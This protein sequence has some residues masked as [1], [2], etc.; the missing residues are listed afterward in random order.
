MALFDIPDI[1][2]FHSTD[3]RF[4]SQFSEGKIVKFQSFSKFPACYKDISFWITS[5]F[6]E[7]N[8]SELVRDT[9][10]DLVETVTLVDEFIHP[11]TGRTS[12]CY[13]IAYR[14][15][16]RSLKNSE[17]DEIQDRVRDRVQIS[18]E[19]DLR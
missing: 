8:F 10:G 7:N 17:V 18:S 3:E 15:F 14:S 2:L 13:R 11:K 4:L 19:M 12:K 6:H 16:S 1:R 5:S 9:A